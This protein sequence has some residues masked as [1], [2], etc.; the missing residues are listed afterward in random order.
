MIFLVVGDLHY[1]LRKFDWVTAAAPATDGVIM[2]GDHMEIASTVAR[3][4]QSVLIDK[5]FKRIRAETALIV[6]SGNH[7]LDT[8]DT[9]GEMTTR[10]LKKARRHN[11]PTDEERF[12][13]GNAVFTV[14]P[15]ID[16]EHQRKA[17][18]ARFEQDAATRRDLWIWVYHAPPD[19]SATSF[20]RGKSWGD[21]WLTE[22]INTFHPDIVLTGHVHE[23]PF[24][25]GGSWVDRM[26]HTWIFNAGHQHGP[27]PSFVLI[28][29]QEKT[30]T[31]HSLAGTQKVRLDAEP[32]TG[33]VTAEEASLRDLPGA[34]V[35]AA[36]RLAS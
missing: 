32:G 22:W 13:L 2:V 5:Y 23:A 24:S 17:Q 19:A 3:P 4:T 12:A 36:Q 16:G 28:D 30:A 26:G 27:F 31:W 7:D 35:H 11:V 20:G 33:A 29:T 10:W 15:W 9:H 21:S 34:I 25:K 14:C 18:Q 1:D 6:S 8:K